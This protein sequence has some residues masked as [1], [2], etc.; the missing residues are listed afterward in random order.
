MKNPIGFE[1]NIPEGS[2]LVKIPVSEDLKEY[3]M[4]LS[5]GRTYIEYLKEFLGGEHNYNIAEKA[6]SDTMHESLASSVV[7]NCLYCNNRSDDEN[8]KSCT[9]YYM[10]MQFTFM[11]AATEFINIVL[12]HKHIYNN[13]S[14]LQELTIN[15]YNSLTFIKDEG[16]MYLDLEKLCRYILK[17]GFDSVSKIFES[18]EALQNLDIINNSIDDIHQRKLENEIFSKE[19]EDYLELQE[20]YFEGKQR[21]YKEKL[22]I[23]EKGLKSPRTEKSNTKSKCIITVPMTVLYYYYLQAAG[24]LPYFENHPEGKLKGIETLIEKDVVNT[25]AKHFQIKYNIIANYKTNRIAKKQAPNIS[26]VANQMLNDYP[27]AKEIALAEL[28]EAQTKNM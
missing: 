28:K 7:E 15:F 16:K 24:Y 2:K 22:F 21:L 4:K 19:D 10:Q 3:L 13:K 18:S 9:I 8:D 20:K 26:Y 11:V 5:V 12:R 6:L 1:I 27:K 17:A 25:T 14:A 23:E